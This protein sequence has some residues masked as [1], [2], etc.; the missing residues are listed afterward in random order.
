MTATPPEPSPEPPSPL[1]TEAMRKAAVVWLSGLPGQPE[2]RDAAVWCAWLTDA[3]YVVS[4]PGEQRAPG[5]AVATDCRVTGRGDNGARIVTWPATVTPVE[6]G[7]EE[8]ARVVPL[9][10]GKRL[11]LPTTE[12]TPARWAAECTVS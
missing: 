8:W 2:G 11:N 12:D 9:L 10:V 3:L 4:G 7:G 5:L 6:P 1:I